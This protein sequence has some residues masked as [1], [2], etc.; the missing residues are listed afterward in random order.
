MFS[1]KHRRKNASMST[2]QVFFLLITQLAKLGLSLNQPKRLKLQNRRFTS[3]SNQ[4][5]QNDPKLGSVAVTEDGSVYAIARQ[6]PTQIV[7]RFKEIDFTVFGK[8]SEYLKISSVVYLSENKALLVYV[9][10][11]SKSNAYWCW[12]LASSQ[13]TNP[14]QIKAE[15]DPNKSSS[16][17]NLLSYTTR[18]TS[19]IKTTWL[20]EG[21]E[22]LQL[23]L[24][25]VN[26]NR[27]FL[28][29]FSRS[30]Q[31]FISPPKKVLSSQYE[32]YHSV[33]M[34][35]VGDQIM[36]VFLGKYNSVSSA[37]FYR[38]ITKRQ[39]TI[40]NFWVSTSSRT[41][42]IYRGE[43]TMAVSGFAE[44]PT[45][46]FEI[47]FARHV[48][49]VHEVLKVFKLLNGYLSERVA[50]NWR[51]YHINPKAL[52]AVPRTIFMALLSAEGTFFEQKTLW[53]SGK[54]NECLY[55]YSFQPSS[56]GDSDSAVIK[57]FAKQRFYLPVVS[58]NFV[59]NNDFSAV[60]VG[61]WYSLSNVIIFEDV[62]SMVC[63]PPLSSQSASGSHQ[64]FDLENS[65]GLSSNGVKISCLSREE[66]KKRHNCLTVVPGT[67]GCMSCPADD[68]LIKLFSPGNPNYSICSD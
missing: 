39:D 34:T 40:K 53:K 46:E 47:N 12:A 52:K 51:Y 58:P 36:L 56:L 54:A 19:N 2:K 64:I 17:L 68:H 49:L 55:I 48:F 60:I 20:K 37:L 66:A 16:G 8:R 13:G 30:S 24:I 59:I 5:I 9:A 1:K 62:I 29:I 22:V 10:G 31:S 18:E 44:N 11:S 41:I 32:V 4:F 65:P 26:A 50:T 21:K 57:I 63:P 33:D 42:E 7:R 35:N 61:D 28:S 14:Y 15:K 45:T 43:S 38:T 67:L 25:H 23:V 27:A 6:Q 3:I